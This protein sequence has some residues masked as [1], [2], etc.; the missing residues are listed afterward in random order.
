MRA[1]LTGLGIVFLLTLAASLV[2]GSPGGDPVTEEHVGEP[3]SQLGVAPGIEKGRGSDPAP[4]D[5][6]PVDSAPVDPAPADPA[7]PA[8][9]PDVVLPETAHGP[10]GR[11]IGG[12]YP[13]A[14]RF[15]AGPA[16]DRSVVI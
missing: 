5:P 4:V 14:P 13:A 12:N 6:A 8:L 9:P 11:G 3:L 15:E 7:D 10:V 1:G 2:Y 16:D